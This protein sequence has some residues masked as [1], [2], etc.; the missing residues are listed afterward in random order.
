MEQPF[1]SPP[2]F[3][4]WQLQSRLHSPSALA[5]VALAAYALY[6]FFTKGFQWNIPLPIP[7]TKPV[8]FAEY[9]TVGA[10]HLGL[11]AKSVKKQDKQKAFFHLF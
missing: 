1:I 9:A 2:S 8:V 3:S 4:H 7:Q 5:L 11:A 10:V 6:P